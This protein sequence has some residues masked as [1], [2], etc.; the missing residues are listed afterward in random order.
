MSG[1][2]AAH[3]VD[4]LAGLRVLEVGDGVAG[5][6]AT[7]VLWALGADVTT[8]V[9]PA[10]V[11]RRGRPNVNRGGGWP[12][13]L[14]IVLDRGKQIETVA[15]EGAVLLNLF[16]HGFELSRGGLAAF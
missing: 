16:G 4:F 3:R 15:D 2:A 12:S 14:S 10:S 1:A 9:D 6:A 8:V 7:G 5:A 11:H 13:L